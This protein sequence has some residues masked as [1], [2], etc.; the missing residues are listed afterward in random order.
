MGA[1]FFPQQLH[2][3]KKKKMCYNLAVVLNVLYSQFVG[4]IYELRE[5]Y[6]TDM[7]WTVIKAKNKVSEG[8]MLHSIY[9]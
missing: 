6:Y 2:L 5:V 8:C 4:D 1:Y 9:L 3:K 7:S